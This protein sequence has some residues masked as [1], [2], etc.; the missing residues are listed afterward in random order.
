MNKPATTATSRGGRFVRSREK[1]SALSHMPVRKRGGKPGSVGPAQAPV[2]DM[3]RLLGHYQ[4][5]L[6]QLAVLP[7]QNAGGDPER[8][9]HHRR[10]R[11]RGHL[12]GIGISQTGWL[13]VIARTA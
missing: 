4:D 1:E 6:M 2:R 7:F 13:F 9:A 10:R 8:I 5:E 11:G 3:Q 12:H